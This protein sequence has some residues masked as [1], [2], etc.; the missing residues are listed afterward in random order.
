MKKVIVGS[1][2]TSAFLKLLVKPIKINVDLVFINLFNNF[3]LLNIVNKIG[4]N[5]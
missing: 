3:L 2:P 5:S 4:K 1:N